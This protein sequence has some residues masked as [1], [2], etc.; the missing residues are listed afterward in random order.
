MKRICA[1]VL[2]LAVL[3]ALAACGRQKD[4]L[5]DA[6]VA[7][8]GGYV[9]YAFGGVIYQEDEQRRVQRRL[10]E[11][12]VAAMA[13]DDGA[14]YYTTPE[15]GLFRLVPGGRADEL[16]AGESAARVPPQKPYQAAGCADK[17][18]GGFVLPNPAGVSSGTGSY[19]FYALGGRLLRFGQADGAREKAGV[20]AAAPD[21]H[22]V[23]Y[24]QNGVA[25]YRLE[26]P[27]R[28]KTEWYATV[29]DG[30]VYCTQTADAHVFKEL[31]LKTLDGER[32][33]HGVVLAEGCD[34]VAGLAGQ[35]VYFIQGHALVRCFWDGT[36]REVLVD[37][38][39]K[40]AGGK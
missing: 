19:V 32:N 18:D 13:A 14:L 34:K 17:T 16:P 20:Y 8:L 40:G 4:R 5:P 27:V 25:Q 39:E 3:P 31:E 24:Y 30:K 33:R 29:R 35:W 15:G 12:D 26:L 28:H 2:A 6:A 37:G 38:T 9:Y 7:R 11:A 22:S 21:G 10:A 1:A 23:L 36:G